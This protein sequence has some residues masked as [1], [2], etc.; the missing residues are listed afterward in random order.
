MKK[1]KYLIIISLSIFILLSCG[2]EATT[3]SI[4]DTKKK[5]EKLNSPLPSQNGIAIN[6]AGN[7]VSSENYK[8]NFVV[9]MNQ[10]VKD[11]KKVTTKKYKFKFINGN[12]IAR[13]NNNKYRFTLI[14]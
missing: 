7:I 6:S 14:K 1:L 13:E 10:T 2:D 11:S 12:S 4:D 8:F 5:E 3:L 9:G